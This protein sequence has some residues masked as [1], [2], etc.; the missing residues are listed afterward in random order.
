MEIAMNALGHAP[1]HGT[2]EVLLVFG[3]L[4]SCDPGNIQLT[5]Q[6]AKAKS[7]RCSMV[8]LAAEVRVFR[9]LCTTTGGTFS[10]AMN[11]A[12]FRDLLFETIPPPPLPAGQTRAA[13]LIL[14]GFPKKITTTIPT[15]CACHNKF[16]FE[17]Y[18]CPRCKAK[19]CE[20]P[21]DCNIC[22]LTLVSSPHLARSYHHLFPV[23]NYREATVAELPDEPFCYSCTKPFESAAGQLTSATKH[24]PPVTTAPA[25]HVPAVGSTAIDAGT[26][27]YI[28]PKCRHQFCLECDL[29]IHDILRN[30][31]GCCT[32]Q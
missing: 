18:L 24:G 9:E 19:I 23:A 21:T 8:H 16:T 28:C 2:R 26:S 17:G 30:C 20:L 13:N 11:E 10:V 32:T 7:V 5:I 31:P 27:R 6:A 3:S 4:T 29:F 25:P 22:A 12:H 14:M 1:A 15:V